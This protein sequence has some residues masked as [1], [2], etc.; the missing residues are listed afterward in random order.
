MAWFM[1]GLAD[2]RIPGSRNGGGFT[3]KAYGSYDYG[4]RYSVAACS[5]VAVAA[6]ALLAVVQTCCEWAWYHPVLLHPV[7]SLLRDSQ[8][9]ISIRLIRG[10]TSL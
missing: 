4:V 9:L 2:W 7:V 10:V 3:Y 5:S 1:C 6:R 8:I